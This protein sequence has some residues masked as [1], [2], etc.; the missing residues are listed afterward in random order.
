MNYN[1]VIVFLL[2]SLSVLQSSLISTGRKSYKPPINN[3]ITW[4]SWQEGVALHKKSPKKLMIY[5]YTDWSAW[6][7]RMEDSTMVNGAV[8]KNLTQN[9][10]CIKLNAETRDDI[11]YNGH[12]FKF[13]QPTDAAG[14]PNGRGWH[15]LADALL[16]G[17]K[18]YPSMVYFDEEMNMIM[19]SPGFKEPTRLLHELAFVAGNIY[20]TQ[21]WNDYI[22]Q[23]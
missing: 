21:S 14:K 6:N 16:D 1:Y 9:F 12:T 8:I 7:K 15:E 2:V 5:I 13:F 10:H 18:E 11:E 19:Q 3:T 17:G 4:M 20:E 23:K 22:K